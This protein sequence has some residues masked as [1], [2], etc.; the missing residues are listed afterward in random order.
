MWIERTRLL[1]GVG[2]TANE[3]RNEWR[4][5][6]VLHARCN[7]LIGRAAEEPRERDIDNWA[8][9][10]IASSMVDS[11]VA[12][13]VECGKTMSS[14][15]TGTRTSIGLLSLAEPLEYGL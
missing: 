4:S 1:V 13:A 2:R 15:S 8:G 11:R 6:C 12:V 5:L 10:C 7:Y 3:A 14:D 9:H